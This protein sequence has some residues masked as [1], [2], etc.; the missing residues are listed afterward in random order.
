MS[1]KVV[2]QRAMTMRSI[3]VKG[4]C[5]LLHLVYFLTTIAGDLPP[6]VLITPVDWNPF[7]FRSQVAEFDDKFQLDMMLQPLLM[8]PPDDLHLCLFPLSLENMTKSGARYLTR[9]RHVA[10]LL[11]KGDCPLDLKTIVIAEIQERLTPSLWY[12]IVCNSNSSQPNDLI[13]ITSNST[14]HALDRVGSM[15]PWT[16]NSGM[17]KRFE[18]EVSRRTKPY[19]GSTTQSRSGPQ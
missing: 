1:R 6:A 17:G 14:L 18:L 5:L 4:L 15:L 16:W 8:L 12:M 2:T 11:A 13:Y 3:I 7:T 10:L 9:D 19:L